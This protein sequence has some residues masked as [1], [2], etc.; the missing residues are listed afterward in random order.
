M[1]TK[2]SSMT[3]AFTAIALYW[4]ILCVLAF[5]SALSGIFLPA[6]FFLYLIIGAGTFFSTH[7]HALRKALMPLLPMALPFI[8][9]IALWSFFSTPTVFTGRDQGSLSNAAIMLAQDHSLATHTSVSDTFFRYYGEGKALNF[10]GFFY[11]HN[12]ALVTQFPVPYIAWLALFYGVFG[13]SGFTIANGILFFLFGYSFLLLLKE[14]VSRLTHNTTLQQQ[15]QY[16]GI[17]FLLISFPFMW[18]FR[19]TLSENLA[20]FL[21]FFLLLQTMLF[22]RAVDKTFAPL[23]YWSIILTG[24]ILTF[25]RIEGI[26]IFA[27]TLLALLIHPH[28]YIYLRTRIVTHLLTPAIGLLFAF[29]VA[30]DQMTNFYKT[31]IKALLPSS[32]TAVATKTTIGA[33]LTHYTEYLSYG[34]LPFLIGG[35][36]G[37][38]ILWRKKRYEVLIPFFILTPTLIYLISPHISADAPW[39]LRRM[40]FSLFPIGILYTV[41]LLSTIKQHLRYALITLFTVLAL[42]A[43]LTFFRFYENA[44]L[45]KQTQTLAQQ[46]TDTDLILIDAGVS[47]NRFAML[48]GPFRTLHHKNAAYIFN[49][50]D[51]T[52]INFNNFTKIFLI[53]PH[54]D[55]TRYT[56]ILGDRL[57]PLT[58]FTITT[59][60]LTHLP[61][62]RLW[63]FPTRGTITTNNIIY[64]VTH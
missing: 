13:L 56:D 27:F 64:T 14:I 24:T 42:P 32:H 8:I 4:I 28:T 1:T 38:I 40:T 60:R 33:F 58:T 5:V 53:V 9:V 41:V 54:A 35:A 31:I 44:N 12:G 51:I 18:F 49:P 17:F 34:I 19:H 39:M 36:V 57:H 16:Y 2:T 26:A 23:H 21:I 62:T 6:F 61:H 11:N 45:L 46:F 55:A 50:Q 43:T 37:T 47:G 29:A 59:S 25:T 52:R 22:V 7:T 48:A 10:P 20:Q 63:H 30:F 3:T 15:A